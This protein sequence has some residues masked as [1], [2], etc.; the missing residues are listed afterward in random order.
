MVV[1]YRKYR[2]QTLADLYGQVWLKETLLHSFKTGKIS[3]AYLFV[4][5]RGTGKTTTARI[6]AKMLNCLHKDKNSAVSFSEPCN[7][8]DSCEAITNGSYLDV[9]E[10][11][12]ASNRG[13]DDIRDL[14]EKI[15]LAPSQGIYKVYIIDEVHMLTGEA[16]NALLKTLEEPPEH[17]VFILCTTEPKKIPDTIV[18][19]CQKYEF[20]KAKTDDL[21]S[22]L[23]KIADKEKIKIDDEAILEIIACAQGGYRDAVSLLDQIASSTDMKINREF[24]LTNLNL[25]DEKL[26]REFLLCLSRK[27]E[28]EA[29]EFIQEYIEKGR[30]IYSLVREL[31]IAVEN[32]IFIKSGVSDGECQTEF[33]LENLT[34]LAPQLIK[35]EEEMKFAFLPQLLLELLVI[36]WCLADGINGNTNTVL[37]EEEKEEIDTGTKKNISA[38]VNTGKSDLNKNDEIQNVVSL[39]EEEIKEKWPS[40]LNTIKPYNYSLESLLRRCDIAGFDG[41]TLELIVYYKIHKEVLMHPKNL[42][43]ILE[44]LTKSLGDISNLSLRLDE[45]AKPKYNIKD[46]NDLAAVAEEMFK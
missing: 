9:I 3:H 34:K 19:R 17:T 46:E 45:N 23:K 15:K 12:A 38:S 27:K 8:C 26:N 32:E 10:I 40:F 35:C 16:F 36:D 11:D 39:S 44:C 14:R 28:K 4:G 7:K 42:K 20:K 6:V 25:S 22:F 29:L 21:L 13:I 41:K 31:I 5:P 37:Q 24:V 18:S 33:S 2:P 43:I 30:D 1:L